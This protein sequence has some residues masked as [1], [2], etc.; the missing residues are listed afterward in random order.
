MMHRKNFKDR[1]TNP[2]IKGL[3][4]RCLGYNMQIKEDPYMIIEF[5]QS[6]KEYIEIHKLKYNDRRYL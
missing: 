4:F 1:L 2:C 3:G 5:I 6:Y